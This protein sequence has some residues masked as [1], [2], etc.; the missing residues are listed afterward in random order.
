MVSIQVGLDGLHKFPSSIKEPERQTSAWDREPQLPKSNLTKHRHLSKS[1][2]TVKFSPTL[3]FRPKYMLASMQYLNEFSPLDDNDQTSSKGQVVKTRPSCGRESSASVEVKRDSGAFC[4]GIVDPSSDEEGL[5]ARNIEYDSDRSS[6][7]PEYDNLET[8]TEQKKEKKLTVGDDICTMMKQIPVGDVTER[9]NNSKNENHVENTKDASLDQEEQELLEALDDM[10]NNIS[11]YNCSMGASSTLPAKHLRYTDRQWKSD[12]NIAGQQGGLSLVDSPSVID[13]DKA[14]EDPARTARAKCQSVT[15]ADI[16]VDASVEDTIEAEQTRS[17]VNLPDIKENANNNTT[18][19]ENGVK[20]MNGHK[21]PSDQVL[22]S[23]HGNEVEIMQHFIPVYEKR[24]P[25][26]KSDSGLMGKIKGIFSRPEKEDDQVSTPSMLHSGNVVKRKRSSSFKRKSKNRKGY[27]HMKKEQR[28]VDQMMKYFGYYGLTWDRNGDRVRP[29]K[30]TEGARTEG[31]KWTR[32]VDACGNDR[33]EVVYANTGKRVDANMVNRDGRISLQNE[34]NGTEK[35]LL[36]MEKG[37]SFAKDDDNI[38][39]LADGDDGSTSSASFTESLGEV[40][41]AFVNEEGVTLISAQGRDSNRRRE[42]IVVGEIHG[43]GEH[44]GTEGRGKADSTIGASP[45]EL[46]SERVPRIAVN[47]QFADYLDMSNPTDRES[48]LF[49]NDENTKGYYQIPQKVCRMETDVSDNNEAFRSEE[50]LVGYEYTGSAMSDCGIVNDGYV[51]DEVPVTETDTGSDSEADER[52]ISTAEIQITQHRANQEV[53]RQKQVQG[54]KEQ[55]SI[56][57]VDDITSHTMNYS[58]QQ[59]GQ[60]QGNNGDTTDKQLMLDNKPVVS[61]YHGEDFMTNLDLEHDKF[62]YTLIRKAVKSPNTADKE[63]YTECRNA[64]IAQAGESCRDRLLQDVRSFKGQ[65]REVIYSRPSKTRVLRGS[66]KRQLSNGITV[67]DVEKKINMVEELRSVLAGW[68][69]KKG[70]SGTV[71]GDRGSVLNRRSGSLRI[72]VRPA[73]F[74]E[75][76]EEKDGRRIGYSTSFSGRQSHYI[77]VGPTSGRLRLSDRSRSMVSVLP[78]EYEDVLNVDTDDKPAFACVESGK[79]ESDKTAAKKFNDRQDEISK[80]LEG[81]SEFSSKLDEIFESFLKKEL[82]WLEQDP[83]VEPYDV[84]GQ[85]EG[86]GEE[87]DVVLKVLKDQL[88]GD[89]RVCKGEDQTVEGHDWVE[90][91]EDGVEEREDGVAMET[92]DVREGRDTATTDL[93]WTD[94]PNGVI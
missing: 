86:Q 92:M 74:R 16:H 39:E 18:S 94:G 31:F 58:Y 69:N 10:L 42:A 2:Q 50:K 81:F 36:V 91:R 6:S 27:V 22:H 52:H 15:F 45:V 62:G 40:N 85:M 73:Y 66:F 49:Y 88:L 67:D 87:T 71:M 7:I 3:E 57:R 1:L 11:S 26:P 25:Q 64:V 9:V 77:D 47:K 59:P 46:A 29:S 90:E 75:E 30:H 41:M 35:Q 5:E 79:N 53:T 63:T 32:N 84:A 51:Y 80:T 21:E 93:V 60:S 89:T 70:K 56:L 82:R 83:C 23:L 43:V 55:G 19:I 28:E 38:E 76:E 20:Q 24:E 72:P 61:E 54:N 78:V 4:I 44:P 8:D 17:R 37:Y 68:E 14:W 12:F 34:D 33:E 13:V 65:T 48:S